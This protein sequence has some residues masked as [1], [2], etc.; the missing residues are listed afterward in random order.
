MLAI[1]LD[2]S[3]APRQ[4]QRAARAIS[5]AA[6]Q[7]SPQTRLLL[8]V[9]DQVV[10]VVDLKTPRA[11]SWVVHGLGASSDPAVLPALV[12]AADVRATPLAHCAAYLGETLAALRHHPRGRQRAA[13]LQHH[14]RIMTAAADIALFLLSASMAA[15]DAQ[16]RAPQQQGQQGA[17]Q[18]GGGGGG[19]GGAGRLSQLA[20]PLH[21]G[22]VMVLTGLPNASCH[23]PA[24]AAGLLQA[25]DEQAARQI[26]IMCV[27][28]ASKACSL[29]IPVGEACRAGLGSAAMAGVAVL[30]SNHLGH[31][32][33]LMCFAPPSPPTHTRTHGTNPQTSSPAAWRRRRR[34]CCRRWP[35]AA[36]GAA[37]TSRSCCRRWPPTSPRPR[38][39]ALA[40]RAC[41][42]CSCHRV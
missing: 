30:R 41:W 28:L 40:T 34:C 7:L 5:S 23:A 18:G 36:T 35:R 31:L 27:A 15:W 21:N 29:D 38:R 37:C 19:S 26:R 1:V 33:L 14:L 9:V 32:T 6:R 17:Q 25:L 22:R 20:Q 4:L 13:G 11:Q 3:M 42:M 16:H 8:L 2:A 39:A 12:Q 24:H 10:S